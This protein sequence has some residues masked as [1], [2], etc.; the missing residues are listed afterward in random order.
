MQEWFHIH[1][2]INVIHHINR[3]KDKNHMI[4]SMDTEKSISQNITSFPNKNAQQN[5]YGKN[6][7]QFNKVHI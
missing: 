3:N 7:P 2:A 6:I 1:K 5:G 4:V